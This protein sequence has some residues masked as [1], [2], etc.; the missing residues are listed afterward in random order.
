MYALF[1]IKCIIQ[2]D[3][4]IIIYEIHYTKKVCA[5]YYMKCIIQLDMHYTSCI[6]QYTKIV[7]ALPSM[8]CI[9]QIDIWLRHYL[10]L[11]S[12]ESSDIIRDIYHDK[13]SI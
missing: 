4:C 10:E 3:V 6:M 9:V 5:L 7:C 12:R 8:K 11:V 2:I 1:S 13:S